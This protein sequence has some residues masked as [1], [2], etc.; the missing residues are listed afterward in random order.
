VRNI[1]IPVLWIVLLF[2]SNAIGPGWNALV[3]AGLFIWA[4]RRL[5]SRSQPAL[6]SGSQ[7]PAP[8]TTMQ[9]V[10]RRWH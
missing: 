8:A 9:V 5:R 4:F 2:G 1:A 6:A 7:N 3:V 10:A